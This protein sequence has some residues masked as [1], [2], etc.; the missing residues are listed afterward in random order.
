MP[1]LRLDFGSLFQ[2]L[3]GESETSA[4]ARVCGWPKALAPCVLWIDEIEKGLA[5]IQSSGRTDSGVT[6]RVIGI[7]SHVDAGAKI[8]G[9]HRSVPRTS[10]RTYPPSSSAGFDEIFFVDLPS[11][12]GAHRDHSGTLIAAQEARPADVRRASTSRAPATDTPV[13]R[14]RRRIDAVALL[15]AFTEDGR[16]ITTEDVAMGLGTIKPLS[17]MRPEAI[18]AMQVWAAER[19]VKANTP[20]PV[21]GSDF[22]RKRTIELPSEG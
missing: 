16:E 6:A 4:T 9:V 17:K 7:I 21:P 11:R 10:T 8:T 5:G 15:E 18:E 20:D 3:M 2:S 13:P 22:G 19:C 14:S 1:L 12:T